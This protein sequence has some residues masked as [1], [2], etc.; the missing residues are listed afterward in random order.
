MA[1]RY[2]LDVLDSSEI[3]AA[4]RRMAPFSGT[5]CAERVVGQG[6][7]GDL[8]TRLRS[9]A[10]HSERPRAVKSSYSTIAATGES[11]SSGGGSANCSVLHDSGSRSGRQRSIL[12]VPRKRPADAQLYWTST[13]R[14]GD[15]GIHE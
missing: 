8:H 1:R 9:P 15:T 3:S 10:P 4:S 7:A 14:S 13:T 11:D 6:A 2:R 5:E 12:V